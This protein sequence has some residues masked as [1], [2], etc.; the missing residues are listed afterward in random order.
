MF[1]RQVR[2]SAAGAKWR[3]G[4]GAANDAPQAQLHLEPLGQVRDPA[5]RAIC[6]N[7]HCMFTESL[8]NLY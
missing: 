5:A 2:K 4:G 6:G 1:V 8:L 7:I 3:T